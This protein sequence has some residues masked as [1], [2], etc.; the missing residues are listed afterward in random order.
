M[1]SKE[2]AIDISPSDFKRIERRAESEE[3]EQ[4]PSEDVDAEYFDPTEDEEDA[5]TN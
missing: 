4:P 1:S 2:N 3:G 5:S